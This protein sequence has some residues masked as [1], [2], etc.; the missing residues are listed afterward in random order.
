MLSALFLHE[1]IDILSSSGLEDEL[2]EVL[3][4][5]KFS[6]RLSKEQIQ[7][8]RSDFKLAVLSVEVHSAVEV[9]KDPKDNFLLALAK[10]GAADFLLTGDA[11]LLALESFGNTKILTIRE[12][13]D[14][15]IEKEP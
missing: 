13:T 1:A 11:E 7:N 14:H 6:K 12:F 4:R 3:E 9:C 2:F 15:L 8:F 5:P 10:D